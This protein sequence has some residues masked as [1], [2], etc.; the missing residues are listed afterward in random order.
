MERI[1]TM[2]FTNKNLDTYAK[3]HNGHSVYSEIITEDVLDLINDLIGNA[4]MKNLKEGNI[5]IYK[6]WATIEKFL[7]PGNAANLIMTGNFNVD[8]DKALDKLD[9]YMEKYP[10]EGLFGA[11]IQLIAELDAD[12]KVL[13]R[14]GISPLKIKEALDSINL[15]KV[16]ELNTN[17]NKDNTDDIDDTDDTN[18]EA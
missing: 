6:L 4:S 13:S 7:T 12:Q 3:E 18:D 16:I 9:L 1:F 8:Y 10:D 14:I 15:S 11:Y 5:N 2:R 17:K